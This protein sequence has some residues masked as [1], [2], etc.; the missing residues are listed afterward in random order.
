M[1]WDR[2]G[3]G[4]CR[5]RHQPYSQSV[6]QPFFRG[7]GIVNKHTIDVSLRCAPDRLPESI[8][9]ISSINKLNR[10]SLS[11]LRMRFRF[12]CNGLARSL[13]FELLSE[14]SLRKLT[15]PNLGTRE[16]ILRT[17]HSRLFKAD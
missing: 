8:R 14:Q 13:E 7:C 15:L 5:H 6:S 12:L 10:L 1:G 11:K 2:L 17:E 4:R 9:L 16:L 3:R